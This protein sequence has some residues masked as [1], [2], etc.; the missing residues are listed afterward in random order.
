MKF[1][2]LAA[3]AL[4]AATPAVAQDNAA[5]TGIRAEANVGLND[6][7]NSPD[8]NDVTYGAQVGFDAPVGSNLTV[9][10]EANTSNIF[11]SQRQIGAAARV[12]YAFTPRA[13]GYVK[14]G[15]SN[16]RDVFSRELDGAVVG[17]GLEYKISRVAYVKGEY[18]YSDFARNTGSHAVLTGIGLRF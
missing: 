5:F 12:G 4:A 10:L 11:E 7:L 18:N 15:Y 17:A 9:G 1:I 6:V 2:V 16:Y 14:G 13:L 3:A 8:R